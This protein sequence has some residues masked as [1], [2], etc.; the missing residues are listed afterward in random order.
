LMARAQGAMNM[1]GGVWPLVHLRSFEA[2]FG[3]KADRW[4]VCTVAG[5]LASVGYAQWRAG[6][7]QDWRHARRL[8]MSTAT[9]LLVVD[10]VNVPRG[11]IRATY[12]VDAAAEAAIL[13]GWL[14]TSMGKKPA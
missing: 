12:L 13:A 1:V 10:L 6:T 8:G 2:V 3:P 5:L 11:R 14:A 4:L 7:E 9:T